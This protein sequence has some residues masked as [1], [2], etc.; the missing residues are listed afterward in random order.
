MTKVQLMKSKDA[1]H[2]TKQRDQYHKEMILKHEEMMIKT[3]LQHEE[4]MTMTKM[5][6][7]KR[8]LT[9]QIELQSLTKK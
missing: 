5:Q 7:E 8:M 2:E 4:A 1:I 6:H 9:L 3:Q